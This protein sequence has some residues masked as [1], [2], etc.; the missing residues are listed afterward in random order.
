[1]IKYFED[2][3]KPVLFFDYSEMFDRSEYNYD[4]AKYRMLNQMSKTSIDEIMIKGL[5]DEDEYFFLPVISKSQGTKPYMLIPYLF[6]DHIDGIF[7]VNQ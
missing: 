1:M 2:N 4:N 6:P 5:F 3:V 7:N